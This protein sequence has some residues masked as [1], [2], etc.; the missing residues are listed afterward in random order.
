MVKNLILFFVIL[1]VS[2]SSKGNRAWAQDRSC[3]KYYD[4]SLKMIVYTD[5]S[6]PAEYPDGMEEAML[7]IF[8]NTVYPKQDELQVKAAVSFVVDIIGNLN[9]IRIYKKESSNY[10]KLDL[11]LI[12]TF[13][14]MKRWKP[15][16]CNGK[17]VAS[18]MIMTLH[19][20]VE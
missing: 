15:G 4:K 3:L 2:C 7:F 5:P 18:L 16:K 9:D 13:R 20:D 10:S 11:E 6:E 8:R 14:T 12:K 19:I 1:L 17:K